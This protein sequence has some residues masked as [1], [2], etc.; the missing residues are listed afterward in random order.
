MNIKAWFSNNMYNIAC[1]CVMEHYAC[2]MDGLSVHIQSVVVEA[3]T[4]ALMS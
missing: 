4:L 3:Q 2:M 1:G